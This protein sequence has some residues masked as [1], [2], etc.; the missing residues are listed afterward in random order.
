M[1]KKEW[2]VLTEKAIKRTRAYQDNREKGIVDS[3]NY[4]VAYIL[5]N[6]DTLKDAVAYAEYEDTMLYFRS[7]E[8][9]E[10]AV[11]NYED[12]FAFG[13]D[14]FEWLEEGYQLVEMSLKFH[15]YA[16]NALKCNQE[17]FGIS[18]GIQLYLDYCKQNG[19]EKELLEKETGYNVMDAMALYDEQAVQAIKKVFRGKRLE[20]NK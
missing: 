5:T 14:L 6:G 17:D 16:W 8:E 3:D 9:S 12:V 4:Q 2:I 19:I 7:L 20:E 11:E 15:V 18:N 13:C 1:D 10:H